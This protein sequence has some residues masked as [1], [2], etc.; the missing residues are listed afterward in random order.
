MISYL[1]GSPISIGEE[2]FVLDV[3]GVGYEI[4]C[5]RFTL[6]KVEEKR[7]FSI[8]V[9]THVRQDAIQLFGFT[10]MLEKKLFLSLITVNGV[11]PKM[12]IGILSGSTTDRIIEMIDK[13]DVQALTRLP[14]VGK[15]KAQQIVFSLKGKI[16]EDR[17]IESAV[18]G[19]AEVVSALVHLGFRIS[20]VEPV[21]EKMPGDVSV[22][23]GIRLGL[24][25]LTYNKKI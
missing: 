16:V 3:K 19:R 22:Q 2:N 12:A 6:E 11:G 15:K 24:A 21:V 4:F 5:S 1:K 8:F 9:H 13:S 25:A 14:R 17:L 23:E 10:S 7:E 20:E 18:S